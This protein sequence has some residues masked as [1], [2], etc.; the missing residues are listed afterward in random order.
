MKISTIL[1]N[2]DNGALA[3]PTFQRGF[4]WRRDQVRKFME[5]L[6]RRHPVGS[7]LVW[8]TTGNVDARGS[9]SKSTGPIQLLLDGQQRIT[10]LYGIMRG[11]APRFFDGDEKAFTGLH[12]NLKHEEFAFYQKSR[13]QGDKLWIDVTKLFQKGESPF[14]TELTTMPDQSRLGEFINRVVALKNIGESDLHIDQVTGE[15]KTTDVVV[16]IFN[17]VNRGGTKLSN[18]DLAL[19]EICASWP[20]ARDEMK[21]R[22]A[23][24]EQ[25]GFKFNLDWL[26]RCINA[27]VTGSAPFSALHE[28]SVSDFESGLIRAEQSIDAL[29]N[30]F[31]ARLGLDH[32]R[33]LGSRYAFPL[34]GRYLDDRNGDFGSDTDQGQLMYWYIHTM[35]WGRYSGSTETVLNQDLAVIR[36]SDGALDRLIGQLRQQR[37]DLSVTPGDLFGAWGRGSRFYPL[38]YMLTRIQGTRD[39][40]SGIQLSAKM[41]GAMGQLHL[42]HIFPKS[43]LYEDDA[44]YS[45]AEVNSLANLTFLTRKTNLEVSNRNPVEYLPEY[46]AKH[47]G[48]VE[49]HWM[50]LDSTLWS[51]DRY[52]DFLEARRELLAAATN[53]MLDRLLHGSIESSAGI[54]NIVGLEADRLPGGVESEQEERQLHA[55]NA[56]VEKLGLPAGELTFELA[57]EES[58]KALAIIDLAWPDGVQPG[59]S[60]PV[61]LLIDEDAKTEQ[62]VNDAGYRFFT[63]IGAFQRYVA[64]EILPGEI[65]A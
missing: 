45:M 3:L 48:A 64:L 44:K 9:S 35:L 10:T 28:V 22:L 1:D 54:P 61:A 12:F 7:L 60:V 15:D 30:F 57:D 59:L 8:V 47:D 36:D 18:G 34:L 43:L 17:N 41:L 39:W 49:S 62:I 51:I 26:L 58:G 4:V 65:A 27:I 5:S 31:S 55:C 14:I 11:K 21:V 20:E 42:H 38:L 53:Q 24:W 37:G 2:V 40:G 6:Y 13:M 29:L 16:E 33:V 32:D 56:W 19:A 46:M 52:R 25:A 63:D 23:K 50:P